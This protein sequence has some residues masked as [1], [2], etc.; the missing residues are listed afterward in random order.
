MQNLNFDPLL[1]ELVKRIV[2]NLRT[3]INEAIIQCLSDYFSSLEPKTFSRKEAAHYIGI[4]TTTLYNWDKKGLLK[5][6]RVGRKCF[7]PKSKLDAF[8]QKSKSF[9]ESLS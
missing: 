8:L 7:Y 6:D 3:E 5:P 2:P 9:S 4:T 1:E